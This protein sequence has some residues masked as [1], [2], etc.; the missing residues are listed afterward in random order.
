MRLRTGLLLVSLATGAP[1]LAFAI[2]ASAYISTEERGNLIAATLARNRA[3]L[4]AV[5]AELQAALQ[6]LRSLAET[7]SLQRD[8]FQ[9]FYQDATTTLRT[10]PSWQNVVLSRPDGSQVV[11]LRLRFGEVGPQALDD[12]KSF[13]AAIATRSA[14]IGNLSFAPMLANEPG[15][16]VRVPVVRA[17]AVA[18]VLTAVLSSVS[19]QSLLESQH[20]SA[21]WVSGLVGTDGRIIAR[22]PRVEA[23]T[24]A[25]TDYRERTSA[26]RDGWYRGKTIEGADTFTAFSRSDLTGWTIGYA[27]PSDAILGASQRAALLM[28]LGILLSIATAL[29]IAIWL[30]QRIVRPMSEL[31]KSAIA[32]GTGAPW[33]PVASGLAEIAQLSAA[34]AIAAREIDQ[35]DR[36]IEKSQTQLRD[37]AEALSRADANRI[38]FLTMLAHELRN[39]LAPLRAGLTLV[40]RNATDPSMDKTHVMMRNQLSTMSRLIDDL[41][42]IGRIDRSELEM[43]FERI[44]LSEAAKRCGRCGKI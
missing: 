35:R 16:A 18:Y 6:V 4:S 22:V 27:M 30:N 25:S 24:L 1:L 31:A 43:R 36:Q 12:A 7:A 2:L 20:L 15:V 29:L 8:D 40:V 28:S 41:V 13:D 42:D 37:K 38:T 39:F 5:D 34:L 10:Q 3:T 44:D 11:N 33:H 9:S 14:A 23:G 32:L 21:G 26:S 19:F 17:G